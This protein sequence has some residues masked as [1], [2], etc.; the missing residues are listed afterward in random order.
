MLFG[1]GLNYEENPNF[2]L[3]YASK[4]MIRNNI[5]KRLT[6]ADLLEEFRHPPIENR[7]AI[8][9]GSKG[10]VVSGFGF[11]PHKEQYKVVR[12][13]YPDRNLDVGHVDVYTL[14]AGSGWRNIGDVTYSLSSPPGILVDGVLHWIDYKAMNIVGFSL[15]D[16]KFGSLASPPCLSHLHGAAAYRLKKLKGR[17]CVVHLRRSWYLR[18][19]IWFYTKDY[20]TWSLEIKLKPVRFYSDTDYDPL[21]VTKENKVLYW[22]DK[23]NLLCFDPKTSTTTIVIDDSSDLGLMYFSATPHVN[24]LVSLKTLEKENCV[25]QEWDGCTRELYQPPSDTQL[26]TGGVLPGPDY[27]MKIARWLTLLNIAS[28]L[29]C[30]GKYVESMGELFLMFVSLALSIVSFLNNEY[31]EF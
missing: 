11:D 20:N 18:V 23:S 30:L 24:T 22:C 8:S 26:I 14:G 4:D 28:Q 3:Y 25:V 21:L 13:H 9:I 27:W 7:L 16:E 17:L 6:F 2:R 15:Q 12:I 1:I 29:I 5:K 31:N 19:D 10:F